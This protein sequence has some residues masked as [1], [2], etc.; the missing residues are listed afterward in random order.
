ME[1]DAGP[2]EGLTGELSSSESQTEAT[3]VPESSRHQRRPN[4]GARKDKQ[5][6]HAVRHAVLSRFPLQALARLGENTRSLRR[7]EKALRTELKPAGMLENMLFDRL[8]SCYLRLLLAARAEGTALSLPRGAE[9][10]T[11]QAPD[12]VKGELP[13]LVWRTRENANG[14]LLPDLF[15]QLSLAQRYDAHFSREMLRY[16]GFLLL[17]RNK[18][19]SGLEG[20]VEKNDRAKT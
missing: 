6:L 11:M 2:E 17:L 10:A 20:C 18:G 13:A 5:R 12:L 8:W 1:Y 19:G 3:S 7:M 9:D 16:L 14:N 15:Q 4:L